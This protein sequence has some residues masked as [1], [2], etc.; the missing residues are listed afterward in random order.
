[1]ILNDSYSSLK[2][3]LKERFDPS[4]K[5]KFYK[6]GFKSHWKEDEESGQFR[7]TAGQ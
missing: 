3:A 1:M 6:A 2:S 4:S 7:V 5:Q